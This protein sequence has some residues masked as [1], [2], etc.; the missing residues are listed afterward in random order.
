MDPNPTR[1]KVIDI[2][3]RARARIATPETWCQGTNAKDD[4]NHMVSSCSDEAVQWC[5]FGALIRECDLF[6]RNGAVMKADP[7]ATRLYSTC[8]AFINTKAF[9]LKACDGIRIND[10][11]SHRDVIGFL[12]E[13]IEAA[14]NGY[15]PEGVTL[16]T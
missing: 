5:L 2:L 1:D 12:D 3:Q 4:T 7:V 9:A 11:L 6:E 14:K 15:V 8:G 16:A 10:S 13:V